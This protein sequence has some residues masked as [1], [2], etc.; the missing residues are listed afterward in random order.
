M[1]LSFSNIDCREGYSQFRNR[2]VKDLSKKF[3]NVASIREAENFFTEQKI[4]GN[5]LGED[6]WSEIL[7]CIDLSQY[8]Y[9]LA[10]VVNFKNK[11]L[12][13]AGVYKTAKPIRKKQREKSGMKVMYGLANFVESIS[14]QVFNVRLSAKPD[15]TIDSQDIKFVISPEMLQKLLNNEG[16]CF[17]KYLCDDKT[18]IFLNNFRIQLGNE[19]DKSFEQFEQLLDIVLSGL[20][21]DDNRSKGITDLLDVCKR[22]TDCKQL[23]I[24]NGSKNK[25]F[26]K[27]KLMSFEEFKSIKEYF[28]NGELFELG[29]I[30]S[31]LYK[32][33]GDYNEENMS[34]FFA[35]FKWPKEKS[36]NK[37]QCKCDEENVRKFFASSKLTDEKSNNKKQT[38]LDMSILRKCILAIFVSHAKSKGF[39]FN[40]IQDFVQTKL[41]F[42]WMDLDI[43]NLVDLFS[44]VRDS[45]IESNEFKSVVEIFKKSS[46]P[47][48]NRFDIGCL[49]SL[50]GHICR[51]SKENLSLHDVMDLFLTHSEKVEKSDYT[52]NNEFL[53]TIL[54][55]IKKFNASK[56]SIDS[57]AIFDKDTF[58]SRFKEFVV[59]FKDGSNKITF[60]NFRN[61]IKTIPDGY[62]D[63]D[64]LKC[65]IDSVDVKNNKKE[66]YKLF[67]SDLLKKVSEYKFDL[68]KVHS[69]FDK[70]F[71]D[72]NYKFKKDTLECI[73]NSVMMT[74]GNGCNSKDV[75]WLLDKYFA[76]EDGIKLE[77]QAFIKLINMIAVGA[78]KISWSKMLNWISEKMSKDNFFTLN[79]RF[80]NQEIELIVQKSDFGFTDDNSNLNEFLRSISALDGFVND[81]KTL[82]NL[83]L[84]CI[85][86]N[87]LA[88]LGTFNKIAGCCFD[89]NFDSDQ[90][91]RN[92]CSQYIEPELHSAVL[93]KFKDESLSYDDLKMLDKDYFNKKDSIGIVDFLFSLFFQENKGNID[94][95]VLV[96]KLK[97]GIISKDNLESVLEKSE[98]QQLSQQEFIKLIML[99]QD[100]S[101]TKDDFDDLFR[102]YCKERL[103][104]DSLILNGLNSIAG[105]LSDISQVEDLKNNLKK[106]NVEKGMERLLID[107]EGDISLLFKLND[108]KLKKYGL[109]SLLKCTNEQENIDILNNDNLESSNN[110]V[111]SEKDFAKNVAVELVQNFGEGR[112][113]ARISVKDFILQYPHFWSN[114]SSN[115]RRQIYIK[116]ILGYKYS[117][118]ATIFCL[119]LGFILFVP[120]STF[121]Y[122]FGIFMI[123]Y[124]LL[125]FVCEI[126]RNVMTK[127]VQGIKSNIFEKIFVFDKSINLAERL[128]LGA[129]T[130]TIEEKNYILTIIDPEYVPSAESTVS[131]FKDT[132]FR[133]INKT[134][135]LLSNNIL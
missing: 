52:F 2:I 60:E 66:L 124:F 72:Q 25:I 96:N 62:L 94:G 129:Q 58:R 33:H 53:E 63:F 32:I 71:T 95:G 56:N 65:L 37:E 16:K 90:S 128:R 84:S 115:K 61:L 27:I 134:A 74:K 10:D 101:L 30:N 18:K 81:S 73:I 107:I 86:D 14:E 34:N 123:V 55:K 42:K 106:L 77:K 108:L 69:F 119:F 21:D 23:P 92:N 46:F 64:C 112:Y 54:K 111:G 75:E 126:T 7:Y 11:I 105:K 114:L 3:K 104:I 13:L 135:T 76:V 45:S 109:E 59:L 91:G 40:F 70:Y 1:Q 8:K 4:V 127:M 22:L 5:N 125:K 80:S 48:D 131:S 17:V 68:E 36:N 6:F 132:V 133:V 57:Q 20:Q 49:K 87:S 26:K 31:V 79:L 67:E 44:K 85:S 82:F 83:V 43:K 47:V 39:S 38:Q 110:I 103:E 28:P 99:V 51:I 19:P 35:S 41:D 9:K 130:V 113:S 15:N 100:K 93:K 121:C 24:K 98:N 88:D 89:K 97:P 120:C 12:E 122:F 116:M 118:L 29:D 50:L 117:L 102:T 78:Q